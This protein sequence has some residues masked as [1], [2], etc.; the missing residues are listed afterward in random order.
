MIAVR[1]Q[2]GQTI[3][4]NLSRKY[5]T[6]NRAGGV[7]QVVEHCTASIRPRVQIP[8]TPKIIIITSISESVY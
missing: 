2:P 5:P 7:A 3:C 1:S 8:V 4:K 6:P